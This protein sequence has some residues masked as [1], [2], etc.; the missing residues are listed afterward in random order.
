LDTNAQFGKVKSDGLFPAEANSVKNQHRQ[1]R[2]LP[3]R[4]RSQLI[5]PGGV[6]L[7]LSDDYSKPWSSKRLNLKPLLVISVAAF[8]ESQDKMAARH[9]RAKAETA[10]PSQIRQISRRF[11]ATFLAS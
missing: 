6:E 4:G 8:R 7:L 3:A 10:K 9:L 5:S 1:R 11:I 2:T